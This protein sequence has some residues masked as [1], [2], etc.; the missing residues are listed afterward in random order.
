MSVNAT[1]NPPDQPFSS[2][3]S[4]HVDTVG[5]VSQLLG[6]AGVIPCTRVCKA[7][8]NTMQDLSI[9]FTLFD[10]ESIPRIEGRVA[11]A[12]EDFQ[13]MYPRTHSAKQMAPLGRFVGIV[14]QVNPVVFEIF[15]T[16]EDPYDP[17]R[18]M[19]E[20][21]V[22]VVEPESI[23]RDDVDEDLLKALKAK[24]DFD[25]DAEIDDLKK[26]GL[27]IPYSLKTLKVCADHPVTSKGTKVFGYFDADV[28]KQCSAISKAV[29]VTLMRKKVPESTRNKTWCQQKE[30]LA[31]NGHVPVK[32]STRGFY[33]ATNILNKGTCP[34]KQK[35]I[36]STYSRTSDEV[37]EDNNV[38][39][40]AIGGFALGAGVRVNDLFAR[41]NACSGAAPAVPEEVLRPLDIGSGH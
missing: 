32:L 5:R 20:T 22:F 31:E 21:W 14:P 35:G 18:K 4:P 2:G 39:P 34:D 12:R 17:T 25:T 41:T 28:L 40:S 9:W 36:R 1:T 13:F 16:M 30:E 27:L 19:S 7:W 24:G 38:R 11:T 8:H 15:R 29:R 33:H 26:Q 3:P 10:A 23:Y 6:L 37:K